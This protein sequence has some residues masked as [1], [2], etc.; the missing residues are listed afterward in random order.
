MN[1]IADCGSTKCDWLLVRNGRDRDL[2]NTQ[3]FSPFFHTTEEIEDILRSQLLPKLPDWTAAERVWFYGTGIHDEDR[4]AVVRRALQAVFPSVEVEVYHDLL[5]A[6]RAV[7]QRSAGIACILG[8]GSNS[9]YYDGS[10][11][12][13]NVPS[14][15]WLLGDEGSGTHLGKALLRAWFY[16]ELPADLNNAFNAEY[17]EGPVSIK[18][19]IYEKGG[20]AYLATFTTFLSAHLQHPFIR[21]LVAECLGE[22]LDRHVRKYSGYQHVPVH[23]VGAIAHHFSEVLAECLHKRNMRLGLIVRKPVYALGEY[24]MPLAE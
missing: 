7:C 17:P 22:F 2:V 23:F 5:G 24:H 8:T 19:R 11:I 20:N 10:R 12:V 13:D 15:G 4:A 9:C 18:N 6:A 21:N 16:R 14:L 3:G 1:I